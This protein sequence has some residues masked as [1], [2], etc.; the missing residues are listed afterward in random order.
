MGMP[1]FK[2]CRVRELCASILFEGEQRTVVGAVH[3]RESPAGAASSAI[4]RAPAARRPPRTLQ[5]KQRRRGV[6][7]C[8]SECAMGVSH[9]AS[10][11]LAVVVG[12]WVEWRA[13]AGWVN[14]YRALM[15]ALK[16]TKQSEWRRHHA[17]PVM[18]VVVQQK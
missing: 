11:L 6:R 3:V 7:R 2:E 16:P 9:N 13:V 17:Y 12:L 4:V 10:N 18:H 14:L 15:H 5:C 1:W 8:V